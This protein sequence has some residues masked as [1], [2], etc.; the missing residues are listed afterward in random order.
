MKKQKISGKVLKKGRKWLKVV[1]TGKN[2]KYPDDLLIND[3]TRDFTEG[4]E[5][6]DLLVET[7]F[8]KNIQVDIKL[9]IRLLQRKVSG[10]KT[11]K[12]GGAM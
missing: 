3:V 4:Q 12:N 7:E 8:E 2:E 10:I 6:T 5:F 11:L 1:Q 9:H